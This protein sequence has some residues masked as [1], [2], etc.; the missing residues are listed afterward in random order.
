MLPQIIADELRLLTF[1]RP[2]AAMH[3][4]WQAF[5]L[6]GLAFTWLA[7]IGR[8]WDNPKAHL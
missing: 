1:R 6:F 2:S 5:L 3:T 8:Y 4:E 7:G